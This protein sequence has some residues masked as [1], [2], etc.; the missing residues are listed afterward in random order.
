MSEIH[1]GER[2]AMDCYLGDYFDTADTCD[3]LEWELLT[4]IHRLRKFDVNS[5]TQ[6]EATLPLRSALHRREHNPVRHGR[7]RCA[8]IGISTLIAYEDRRGWQ[9]MVKKRSDT[10]VAAHPGGIHVIP[11]FMFQPGTIQFTEEF[12]NRS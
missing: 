4:N 2:L 10:T 12:F 9:L 7:F 8:G 11:A 5:L 6:F 1:C 3:A